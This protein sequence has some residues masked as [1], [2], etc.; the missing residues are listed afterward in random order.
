MRSPRFRLRTLMICIAF[1]ALILAL[2]TQAILL[3]RS[4]A[5]EQQLR[6]EALWRRASEA[7]LQRASA[8]VNGLRSRAAIDQMSGQPPK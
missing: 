8:E 3:Q 4:A 6:A 7:R 2:F 1:L 5:R